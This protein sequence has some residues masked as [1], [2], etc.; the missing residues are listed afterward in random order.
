MARPKNPDRDVHPFSV[1]IPPD[2]RAILEQRA[3]AKGEPLSVYVRRV[4]AQH[5]A[6]WLP[7]ENG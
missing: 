5:A 4:L 2:V 1:R 6:R 7:K 3:A